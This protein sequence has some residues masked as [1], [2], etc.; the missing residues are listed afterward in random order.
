MAKWML[1]EKM[2]DHPV[3]TTPN[4]HPGLFFKSSLLL[5]GWCGIQVPM[6]PNQQRRPLPLYLSSFCEC[7][8]AGPLLLPRLLVF[9][10]FW[11]DCPFEGGGGGGGGGDQYP[12][13]LSL[14]AA[15]RGDQR[16]FRKIT[17][18]VKKGLSFFG[19]LQT[20]IIVANIKIKL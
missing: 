14:W 20:T 15:S 11:T 4:H 12:I 6:S 19:S 9:F 13:G 10:P 17:N 5:N 3:H 8:G 2:A 1:F 16:K 18:S 7:Y